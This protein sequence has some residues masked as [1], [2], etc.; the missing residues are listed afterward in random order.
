M[1]RPVP[2]IVA[3]L[4]LTLPLTGTSVAAQLGADILGPD[5]AACRGAPARAF[6]V[7]VTGFKNR[8]GTVRVRLFGGHPSTYFIRERALIRTQLPVPASGPVAICVPAP[9][10][11]T[12]AIDVRHDVNNDDSTN[13]GDGGGIS[14]NP[15]MSL[16]DV[17]L[18]RRPPAAVTQV[19]IAHGVVT[20]PIT[21][22][23]V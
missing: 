4:G 8:Q 11:G 22:R 17:I 16:L 5:A 20:V 9:A 10:A 12:Y 19:V 2:A 18:R 3:I 7:Q 23:Y 21:I 15:R 13:R 6:L 1:T 14:G